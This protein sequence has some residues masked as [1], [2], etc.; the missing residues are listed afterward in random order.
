MGELIAGD[1]EVMIKATEKMKQESSL[2]DVG[3]EGSP[4]QRNLMASDGEQSQKEYPKKMEQEVERP[5]TPET[6][7]A[8]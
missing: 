5:S 2:G 8:L 3:W 6:A 1:G 4:L 7:R